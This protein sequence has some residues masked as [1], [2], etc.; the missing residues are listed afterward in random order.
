M[1]TFTD[2]RFLCAESIFLKY[3]VYF[4][5]LLLFLLVKQVWTILTASTKANHIEHRKAVID[6]GEHTQT[7]SNRIANNNDDDDEV[8]D[9]DEYKSHL[10]ERAH[11]P[12]QGIAEYLDKSGEHFFKLANDRRSIRQFAKDK[13]VDDCVIKRCILAA[14]ELDL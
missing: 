12:Y 14:G 7:D 1:L 2:L 8:D 11:I 6:I 10:P 13:E 3:C 9:A 4:L 5:P